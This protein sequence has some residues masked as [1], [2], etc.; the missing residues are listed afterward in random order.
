MPAAREVRVRVGGVEQRI[1]LKA[2][3]AIGRAEDVDV[4]FPDSH[5]SRRHAEIHAR[6]D[7]HYVVDLGSTNGTFVNGTRVDRE[8]RL[9]DHDV[10]TVGENALVFLPPEDAVEDL[11]DVPTTARPLPSLGPLHDR[12]TRKALE[13][14]ELLREN[15]DIAIL[16][17]A[18]SALMAHRPLPELYRHILELVFAL[19][20]ADRGALA[21]VD[22]D[23]GAPEVVAGK[24]LPGRDPVRAVS[25]AIARRVMD[26]RVALLLRDVREDESLQKSTSVIRE[27]I[28]SVMCA[29]LWLAGE[30]G[31]PGKV[32]GFLYVDNQLNEAF[33]D[34]DL[35]VLTVIANFAASKIE[36][37]RLFEE[38]LEKRQ[39]E[40]DMMLASRIQSGLLPAAVPAIPGYS[41]AGVTRPS[42]AVGGDYFDLQHDGTLLHMAL[43]DVSGKGLGAAM[44]MVALR[45]TVRS[46]WRRDSL[47][48]AI[49]NANVT[50]RESIPHDQYATFFCARL[51][52]GSGGLR[53]VNAGHNRPLLLRAGGSLHHLADGGTIL[54]AFEDARYQEGATSLFPGDVLVVF[55]DGVSDTW[56]SH[57]LADR[58]LSELVRA[59]AGKPA[60]EMIAAVF[61]Q[62]DRESG[63]R[64]ADDRTLLVLAR[65]Q[66]SYPQRG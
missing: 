51:D 46:H 18:T 14:D 16:S 26:G 30:P 64:P 66:R 39:L 17:R 19:A 27:P 49:R 20:R 38:N 36:G 6:P 12:A 2:R 61:A 58:K 37:A 47:A 11:S 1:R 54:G 48:E 31:T 59:N 57:D 45:A 40:H 41:V 10:I 63:Q 9:R 62:I 50:F 42:R 5:I 55:S 25:S 53:Y 13:L 4:F 60:D 34:K 8:Q 29:P 23:G 15:Q 7:G 35:H 22:G 28:R 21:L 43:G 24:A 44:L 3:T 33:D 65:E 56:A 52:P 32:L